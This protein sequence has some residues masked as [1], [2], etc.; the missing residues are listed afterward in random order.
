LFC[1][2]KERVQVNRVSEIADEKESE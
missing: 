2:H 1:E